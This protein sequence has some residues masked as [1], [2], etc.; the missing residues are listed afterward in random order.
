MDKGEYRFKKV[1]CLIP[2]GD[3]NPEVK[4]LLLFIKQGRI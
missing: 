3:V 2:L 1:V 4:W